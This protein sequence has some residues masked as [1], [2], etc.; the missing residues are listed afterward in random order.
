[1]LAIAQITFASAS[2]SA[3]RAIASS[4]ASTI[5]PPGFSGARRHRDDG[6]RGRDVGRD[7]AEVREREPLERLRL[8]LP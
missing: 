4:P 6:L 8:R 3:I 7:E 2:R 5:S 1:M